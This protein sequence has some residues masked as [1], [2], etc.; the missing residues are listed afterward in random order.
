MCV[1]VRACVCVCVPV[2]VVGKYSARSYSLEIKTAV[3][4][5]WHAPTN[6]LLEIIY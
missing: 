2:C 4:R 6:A 5:D 3:A 1:C